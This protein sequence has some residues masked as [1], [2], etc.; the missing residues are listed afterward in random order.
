MIVVASAASRARY[1][2][3]ERPA[4]S[5]SAGR[6]RLQRDRRRELVGADQAAGKLENALMDRLEEML[7]L[8]EVGDAVERLVIDEDGAEQRLLGLDIVRRRA[9]RRLRRGLLA[10]G[11]IEYW[12]GP[13]KESQ[14][15][16]ICGVA[17]IR[18]RL[19]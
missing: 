12:H 9:E 13:I 10:C 17:E 14:L 15:W 19:G 18:R 3:T 11:R 4:M 7:R 1:W 16:P 2:L 8:E 5:T 6:K